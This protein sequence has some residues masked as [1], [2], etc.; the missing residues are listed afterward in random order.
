MSVLTANVGS[1]GVIEIDSSWALLLPLVDASIFAVL[2]PPPQPNRLV[3]ISDAKKAKHAFLL[4]I[5]CS[6][7]ARAIHEYLIFSLAAR[8]TLNPVIR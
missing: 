3:I 4:T 8:R 6:S 7:S 1:F 5:L 2:P